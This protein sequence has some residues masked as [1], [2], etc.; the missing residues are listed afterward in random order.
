MI[1]VDLAPKMKKMK[2]IKLLFI[3]LLFGF[4]LVSCSKEPAETSVNIGSSTYSFEE[5]S[6][7]KEIPIKLTNTPYGYPVVVT[8]EFKIV[9]VDYDTVTLDKIIE[10][11]KTTFEITE[12]NNTVIPLEVLDNDY[13]NGVVYVVEIKILTVDNSEVGETATTTIT[14]VDNEYAPRLITGDYKVA[15]T[16]TAGS[17]REGAGEFN[18]TLYKTDKYEYVISGLCGTNENPIVW[19]RP[20]LQGVF[21]PA[22]QKLTF[23]GTDYDAEQEEENEEEGEESKNVTG[24][25]IETAFKTA[26]YWNDLEMT[27]VLVF[28]GSGVDGKQAIVIETENIEQDKSGHILSSTSSYGFEIYEYDSVAKKIGNKVGVYDMVS[29]ASTYTIVTDE[30]AARTKSVKTQP[31]P[32][33]KPFSIED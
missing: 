4:C 11:D 29:G 27:E 12:E 10:F 30:A 32:I 23:D 22:T 8:V 21:D 17:T 19:G 16:A 14:I 33:D 1:S 18:A 3:Y 25:K 31:I 24:D 15:Y 6:G 20:R 7:E 5:G 9:A 26:Y 28:V 2:N 13:L